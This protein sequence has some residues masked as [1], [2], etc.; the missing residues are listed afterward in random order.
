MKKNKFHEHFCSAPFTQLIL[1][2]NGQVS[3]CCYLYHINLG[4]M[5]KKSLLEIWN[6]EPI[7]KM[8]EKF[9]SST[10][11]VCQAKIKYLNCHRTFQALN[12]KVEA[13][14]IQSNP[15]V[16]LDVRLNGQCNLACIMCD[17]WKAPNKVYDQTSFWT[18]GPENIFPYLKEIEMLGGEPFVQKDTYKLI[19]IVSSI[20]QRCQWSFVSNAHYPFSKRII[21]ALSKIRIKQLQISLDSLKADVYSQI[22]VGGD[23]QLSLKTLKKFIQFRESYQQTH[24]KGFHFIVSMCVLKSNRF[25]VP[26]FIDFCAKLNVLPQ[27]QYAFYDPSKSQSLNYLS[28]DDKTEYINF[29]QKNIEPI[30]WPL[31]GPIIN[32]IEDE[33]TNRNYGHT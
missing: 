28:R 2:P 4:D 29:L 19:E 16:K 25:E 13:K 18:E 15:P 6:D 11:K 27:F 33:L 10:P 31:I 30:H 21:A 23:L 7:K 3:P 14:S 17:V 32:P 26:D 1:K 22:R 24:G 8:R 5:K 9:L 20:N 12:D